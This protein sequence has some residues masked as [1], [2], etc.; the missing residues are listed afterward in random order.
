VD[1][2]NGVLA[3]IAIVLLWM[4]GVAFFVAFEGGSILGEA[5]P[6]AGGGGANYFKAIL[7]GLAGKSQGLQQ[8]SGE[9]Q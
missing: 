7:Q 2:P 3:A 1:R 9:G 6:A 8:A 5:I 4:A